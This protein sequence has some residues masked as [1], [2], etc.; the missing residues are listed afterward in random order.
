MLWIVNPHEEPLTPA[1]RARGTRR[2]VAA[3]RLV[4]IWKS[5][6]GVTPVRKF[7]DRK[8]RRRG[9]RPRL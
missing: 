9:R 7:T 5:L 3:S 8:G 4:E 1:G 6:T 2:L